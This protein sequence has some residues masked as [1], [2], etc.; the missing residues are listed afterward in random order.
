MIRSEVSASIFSFR[1]VTDSE[2]KNEIKNQDPKKAIP[3][4]VTFLLSTLKKHLR[5]VALF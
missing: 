2:V 5:S 3:P 4:M 1:E